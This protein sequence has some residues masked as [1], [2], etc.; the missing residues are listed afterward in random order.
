VSTAI[1]RS[2][3]LE[4]LIGFVN[5]YDE[6][7]S[8]PDRLTSIGV[9]RE[10]LDR[11]G[12]DAM[13]SGLTARQLPAA[14]RLREKLREVFVLPGDDAKVAVLNELLG[15]AGAFPQLRPAD[16]GWVWA[17]GSRRTGLGP[18][19][20]TFA[21]TL[22]NLLTA[23]AGDRLG[24]CAGHPCRCVF[25][26]VTRSRRQRYCCELCNDRMAAAAYRRRNSP[27]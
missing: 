12:L 7:E 5:T 24:V 3:E 20:A 13:G 26:D 15:E 17:A 8:P 18:L 1:P 19:T 4:A 16:G 23:G 6:L 21:G 27:G 2:R 14:R 25:V 11:Q 10:V 22:G 9:L